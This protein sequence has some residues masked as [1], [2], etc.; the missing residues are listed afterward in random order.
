MHG[1]PVVGVSHRFP[2]NADVAAALYKPLARFGRFA[3]TCYWVN[4]YFYSGART[5]ST[6]RAL[7]VGPDAFICAGAAIYHLPTGRRS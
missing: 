3:A 1:S 4:D 5:H 6:D 7:G 2:V